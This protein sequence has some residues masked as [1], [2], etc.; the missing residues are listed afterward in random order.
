MNANAR[1][2][3]AFKR[4]KRQLTSPI[5]LRLSQ[6]TIAVK[7]DIGV[8]IYKQ[9]LWDFDYD[10]SAPKWRK[11][12][13]FE[14]I[15]KAKINQNKLMDYYCK[16]PRCYV[17]TLGSKTIFFDGHYYSAA[18]SWAYDENLNQQPRWSVRIDQ[19]QLVF[20]YVAGFSGKIHLIHIEDVNLSPEDLPF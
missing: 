4:L 18:P 8:S 11:R 14:A 1:K 10:W 13:Q 12:L 6:L 5:Q 19:Q 20:G 17:E 3:E 15:L 16:R 7:V 9:V 2:K